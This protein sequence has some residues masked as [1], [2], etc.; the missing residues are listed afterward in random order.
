M[1]EVLA[2]VLEECVQALTAEDS[3]EAMGYLERIKEI[4]DTFEFE[5]NTIPEGVRVT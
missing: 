2:M 1:K 3:V 4:L 5:S